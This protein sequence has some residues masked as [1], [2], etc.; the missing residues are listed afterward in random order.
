MRAKM[1]TKTRT[2]KDEHGNDMYVKGKEGGGLGRELIVHTARGNRQGIIKMLGRSREAAERAGRNDLLG[3]SYT[4]D[5]ATVFAMGGENGDKALSTEE[6][7]RRSLD[8]AM[9][10][11]APGRQLQLHKRAVI[12]LLDRR[13]IRT[14]KAI[15][16]GRNLSKEQ[17]QT[18]VT[19][20]IKLQASIGS[21]IESAGSAPPEMVSLFKEKV[22]DDK[23][24]LAEMPESF[25]KELGAGAFDY[26]EEPEIDPAT[27]AAILDPTSGRPKTKRVG[28]LKGEMTNAEINE[29][30]RSYSAEYGRWKREYSRGS[31]AEA[32]ARTGGAPPEAPTPTGPTGP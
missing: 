13:K 20:A 19:E 30:L 3:A 6:V 32:A 28:V 25:V 11:T 27:N 14:H 22:L 7:S 17:E 2:R 1:V 21:M 29:A 8:G 18:A 9:D 23:M 24:Q 12:P 4:E 16:A 31:D 5:V 10:A 15:Q 26:H